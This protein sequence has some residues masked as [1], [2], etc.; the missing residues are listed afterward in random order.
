MCG[1]QL[2]HE[3]I[4]NILQILGLIE[5]ID[6]LAMVNSI[7]RAMEFEVKGQWKKGRPKR[8]C[9]KE[10]EEQSMK[11]GLSREDVLCSSMYILLV[12]PVL[13]FK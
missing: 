4:Y 11:V 5:T 9:K 8:T 12:S 6:Q 1:V 7:R 10:V 3:E 2:K 13:Q